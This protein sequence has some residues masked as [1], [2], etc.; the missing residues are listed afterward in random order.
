MNWTRL[1]EVIAW[2]NQRSPRNVEFTAKKPDRGFNWICNCRV[3]A[4]LRRLSA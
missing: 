4:E 1:L 2:A 3:C